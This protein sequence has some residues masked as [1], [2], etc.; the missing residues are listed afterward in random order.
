MK[1]KSP[2]RKSMYRESIFYGLEKPDASGNVD[3]SL[4]DSRVRLSRDGPTFYSLNVNAF[5]RL[6]K[7]GLFTRPEP[8]FRAGDWL[9]N[10]LET[11]SVASERSSS[12]TC[13]RWMSN[14]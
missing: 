1:E 2:V 4:R 11:G 10:Q 3:E 13:C 6:R 12:A 5:T 9:L 14:R 7:L 8:D